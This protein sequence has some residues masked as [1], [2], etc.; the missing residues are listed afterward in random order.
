MAWKASEAKLVKSKY[1]ISAI[2]FGAVVPYLLISLNYLANS[3]NE[4]GKVLAQCMGIKDALEM[5]KIHFLV[6]IFFNIF[7]IG[8]GLFFDVKMLI[9]VRNRNKIEASQLIPWKSAGSN[10]AVGRFENPGVPVLFGGHNL[11][12]MVGIGLT[13]L[14]PGTTGLSK[15]KKNDDTTVP[16]R[17]SYVSTASLIFFG[18]LA[19]IYLVL[20]NQIG[21]FY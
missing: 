21:K 18:I 1:L 2:I 12:P 19:P 16:L 11:P 14:P 20:A 6:S 10:R 7:L 15:D 8:I 17:A 5:N 13:Y 9:F 3:H 4:G